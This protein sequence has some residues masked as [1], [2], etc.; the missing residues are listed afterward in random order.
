VTDVKIKAVVFDFDGTLVLSNDLKRDAYYTIFP[1]T[2]S[3][4]T[5][6]NEVLARS[7]E[8]SR[9]VIITKILQ[10]ADV[11]VTGAEGMASKVAEFAKHYNTV[12]TNG[13]KICPVRA[14]V[15]SAIP[16]L[17]ASGC[18]LYL[19]STTPEEA[20]REIIEF[21]GWAKFFK[22][23]SGYPRRKEDMIRQ[24]LKSEGLIP[25]ELLV[26]GDGESDR[27]SA[28]KTGV[29]FFAVT[30]VMSMDGLWEFLKAGK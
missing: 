20:L 13:A 4:K 16:L 2:A 15:E 12:V 3:Y 1:A 9:Y 30:P 25:R 19:S 8:E 29:C 5:A 24:V 7:Y 21:R 10:E 22:D 14:G 6:I 18:S 11:E 23:I 27:I 26:V 17:I 28:E